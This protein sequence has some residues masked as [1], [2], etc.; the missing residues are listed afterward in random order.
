MSMKRIFITVTGTAHHYGQEFL[1]K[2]MELKL[3]KEPDNDYDREAIRAE[4]AGLGLIGYVANSP[5]T[6][7]GESMSAG[8]LYDRIGQT[9]RAKVQFVLPAGVVCEVKA[10]DVRYMP[11]QESGQGEA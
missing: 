1:K 9:A 4:I 7:Q 10:E 5:H 2:G 3:V 8:R 6:V 11:P